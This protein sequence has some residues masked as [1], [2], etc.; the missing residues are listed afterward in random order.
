MMTWT[1]PSSF[2]HPPA[3]AINPSIPEKHASEVR[4]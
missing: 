2:T 1:R 4:G 3:P